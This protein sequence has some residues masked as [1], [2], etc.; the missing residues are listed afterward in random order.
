M[1]ASMHPLIPYP[2]VA[3]QTPSDISPSAR[4]RSTFAGISPFVGHFGNRQT[5]LMKKVLQRHVERPEES[6]EGRLEERSGRQRRG[7]GLHRDLRSVLPAF[8]YAVTA[9][10]EPERPRRSVHVRGRE[11]Q[12]GLFADAE[13]GN[14]GYVESV[15]VGGSPRQRE[16]DL[17]ARI[18]L[19]RRNHPEPVLRYDFPAAFVHETSARHTL[20]VGD[21]LG[22]FTQR[23][24]REPH[25]GRRAGPR[26]PDGKYDDGHCESNQ[27]GHQTPV[28]K[29][30]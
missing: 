22:F 14:A 11:K 2:P 18:P 25:N 29:Q 27:A 20:N 19:D 10:S 26:S 13:L 6:V 8:G 28:A 9:L 21:R 30:E 7:A 3:M 4:R 5:D 15:P 12:N 24:E 16:D 1:K 17:D 23:I